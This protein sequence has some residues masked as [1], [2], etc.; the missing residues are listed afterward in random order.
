LTKKIKYA[1]SRDWGLGR[2]FYLVLATN[3]Q[4]PI[5]NFKKPMMPVKAEDVGST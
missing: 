2:V 5:L 1:Y 4:F 3:S